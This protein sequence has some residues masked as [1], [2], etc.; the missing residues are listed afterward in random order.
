MLLAAVTPAADTR[1]RSGPPM[2]DAETPLGGGN[3]SSR[4]VRAG[5]TMRRPAGPWTPAAR[6]PL[7]RLH[8]AGFHAAPR[9]PGTDEHG[10]E[11]LTF[12]PGTPAWPG[13]SHLPD[14]DARLRRTTRLIRDF[15]D[16]VTT[17]TPPPAH[18]GRHS[19][20]P[21]A[22]RSSPTTTW[23]HGT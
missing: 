15:H 5:D 4:V 3:M 1:S 19:P 23:P 20:R 16:A 21:A 13:Q 9:P 11:V 10:R 18:A 7:T 8:E 14:E 22:T 2:T 6:A 17:F 12:I